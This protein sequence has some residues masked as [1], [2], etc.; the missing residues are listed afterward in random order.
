MVM[1]ANGNLFGTASG[2]GTHN[3][4]MVYEITP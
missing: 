3:Y 2:G 4:G 1:D